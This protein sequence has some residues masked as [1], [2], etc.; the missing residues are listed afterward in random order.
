MGNRT[1]EIAMRLNWSLIS[2]RE[3]M[4]RQGVGDVKGKTPPIGQLPKARLRLSKA[5][6]RQQAAAA[7]LAWRAERTAKDK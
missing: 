5:E 3:R 2:I 4:R 1:G 6:R 7:F